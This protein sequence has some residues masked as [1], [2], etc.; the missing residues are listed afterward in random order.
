[1]KGFREQQATRE[2]RKQ[3][4][5]AKQAEKLSREN[6]SVSPQPG[7]SHVSRAG[8]LHKSTAEPAE[9]KKPETAVSRLQRRDQLKKANTLPTSVTAQMAR[10]SHC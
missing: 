10:H 9:E 7:S 2:E 5:D 3:A 1:Q 8:S 6:V 4:R